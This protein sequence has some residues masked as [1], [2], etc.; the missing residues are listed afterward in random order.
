MTWWKTLKARW[1]EMLAQYG[2]IALV[3]WF[4]IFGLVMLGNVVALKSGFADVGALG[5]AGLI[6]GAYV[7]TQATKPIRIAVTLAVTPLVARLLRREPT[8]AAATESESSSP[9][10]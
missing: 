10:P 8:A 6:G 3:V 2:K 7:L 1:K 9:A 5:G 4:T